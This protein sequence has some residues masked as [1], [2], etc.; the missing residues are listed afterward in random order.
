MKK[1]LLSL[2]SLAFSAAAAFAVTDGPT[3]AA[4]ASVDVFPA[5]LSAK[6]AEGMQTVDYFPASGSFN[7]TRFNNLAS[8]TEVMQAID[9][10]P[11]LCAEYDGNKITSI[12][13]V[14][15][16][17]ASFPSLNNITDVTVFIVSDVTSTDYLVKKEA[18]LSRTA[19]EINRIEL[20]TPFEIQA[21]HPFSIGYTLKTKTNNEYYLVCDATPTS[22]VGGCWIKVGTQ[23][24]ANYADQ[25]GNLFIGATI[26]GEKMPMDK[27]EVKAFDIPSFVT[28]GSEFNMEFLMI[29][30]AANAAKSFEFSIKVGDNEPVTR[31]AELAEGV[32]FG[33]TAP[34]AVS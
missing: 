31:S 24:W 16:S 3:F 17:H 2:F 29:G 20:D 4:P 21:G 14:G 22:E 11:E 26:E 34:I 8:G 19:Y 25:I 5:A 1:P 18:K 32:G 15:G 9:F 13:I 30:K 10:S 12:N 23:N 28:T 27:A 33:Q 6:A 7:S